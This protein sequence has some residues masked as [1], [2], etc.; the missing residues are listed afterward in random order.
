MAMATPKIDPQLHAAAIEDA[1]KNLNDAI[2]AAWNDGLQVSIDVLRYQVFGRHDERA[3][4]EV[5]VS[6][7]I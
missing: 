3:R 4:V 6:K 7:P 1:A 5:R 2:G